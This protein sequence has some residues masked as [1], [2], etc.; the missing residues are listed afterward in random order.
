MI[1]SRVRTEVDTSHKNMGLER[2]RVGNIN[3]K[4]VAVLPVSRNVPV[5]AFAR[6]LHAALESIGAPTAFLNQAS[7]SDH[8]GRHAF[9]RMGKLKAAGWLAEQEQKYRIVLYVA[10]SAV[11]S[12]WTQTCIRQVRPLML[13]PASFLVL[14][15][16]QADCVM[17]VGMGDD[18]S[19]GEFE[20][21][22]LS[23]KTTAR[24]ELVLLHPDRSVVPGT[25]REWLKVD[26]L[27]TC[28][29]KAV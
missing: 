17:L 24:K 4:N 5:D 12:S 8:L 21:L 13:Y 16:S 18:P 9:S 25:T 19:I 26:R 10:D 6:K 29:S 28:H 23:L 15:V 11:S 27:H 20:R 22:L 1:A 2:A 14:K 3:L 7:V